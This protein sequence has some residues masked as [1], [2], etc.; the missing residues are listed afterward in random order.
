MFGCYVYIVNCFFGLRLYVTEIESVNIIKVKKRQD[1]TISRRPSNRVYVM[2]ISS[3]ASLASDRTSQG[4]SLSKLERSI[5]A[6][7][8]DC[9]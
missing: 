8:N 5:T 1:I 2:F 6:R 4:Y 3:T 7:H 9:T